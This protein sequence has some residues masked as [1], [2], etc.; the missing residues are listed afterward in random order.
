MD[1]VVITVPNPHKNQL[2]I[3]ENRKRFNHIRCGRRFGKT[4]FLIYLIEPA[5]EENL[6]IGIINLDNNKIGATENLNIYF[7]SPD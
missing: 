6:K 1:Q 5:I 4:S 7:A 3:I 2:K